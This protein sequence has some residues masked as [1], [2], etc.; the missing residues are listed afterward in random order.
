MIQAPFPFG[1]EGTTAWLK[2]IAE[3]FG[4]DDATFEEVTAA[5]RARARTAIAQ[6]SEHLRGKSVFFFPDSQLEIPLA[7]FLTRECGMEAV[8]VGAALYPQGPRR[9][10]PRPDPR[11]A[12]HLRRPGRGPATRPRAAPRAPT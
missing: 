9:P 6:A 10:R 12:D 11:R 3:E 7:R 2:A 4:V 1:E 5:P 8:E